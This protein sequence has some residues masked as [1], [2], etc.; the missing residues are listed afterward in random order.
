MLIGII[1]VAVLAGAGYLLAQGLLGNKDDTTTPVPVPTVIGFP[2]DR[3]IQ[4]LESVNLKAAV[5]TKVSAT[6]KPGRVVDQDPVAG[7][8]LAPGSTVTI[9]VAKAPPTV[10]VPTFTGLTLDAAQTLADTNHL[11]LRP[12]DGVSDTV[13]VGSI[14]S[15]DPPPGGEVPV[16]SEV[17]VVV[18]APPATVTVDDVTCL[19]FGAAKAALRDQGLVAVLGGTAP[20]LPQCPNPN[21]IAMQDPAAGATVD[22]GSTVTLFTGRP[23]RQRVRQGRRGRR[24]DLVRARNVHRGR[25]RILDR[26]FTNLDGPV[27]A[28][29]NLPEVVKGRCS[30]GTPGR[31][32]RCGDCSWTSSLRGG[33][34]RRADA[35]GEAR[36]EQLYERVFV[37]YGDDSVAQLGGVHL[38]C[39]QASQ[40]L[41]KALEWGRLAAYLEQ[42]TRYMRYDDKP[43]GAWRATVPPEIAR[44]AIE[45]RFRA[46]LDSAFTAYGRMYEPLESF[47][48]ERFPKE[49]GDTDFVY[50][51]TILAKTC[52]TL[53][54]LLPA[55]TRSNLGIYA[56]GQSYEQ[57]LMRL[58]AH[59]LAEM[60]EYGDLMLV[61][62][63]KVIP[64][65]LTRV[66]VDERGRA[67]TAYWRETRETVHDVTAKALTGIDPEPRPE[68]T[69]TDWDPDGEVKVI[70]AALYAH[71]DLPDDQLLALARELTPEQRAAVLG[72]TVGDRANRRH[73]PGR[74]WE[75]TDYRFDVCCD[76]GAFRDL[77]RHRPLTIEWQRLT[78]EHGF[79]TPAAIDE[80][81]LR[82]SG[83]GRW[84]RAPSWN[85]ISGTRGWERP[86]NTPWRWRTASG[87][88]CR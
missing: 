56:T 31:R 59:P 65:F 10:V 63:R 55:S 26:H 36:A 19:S 32:S 3:A 87:S 53:R 47:F 16:G 64:A 39:E 21:R 27:F 58:A 17:A 2:Q 11:V 54:L 42:S 71:S 28:L 78:T 33:R 50:R 77:Q 68:V 81:G 46:H 18:S 40:L 48:M 22:V 61:E 66:D 69:L 38:A 80:A 13:P 51:S 14:I 35:A 88:S 5:K 8:T 6:V 12:T 15:Q 70:A 45:Q 75:R 82:G 83:I 60:R 41:C 20:L 72:A 79:D 49:D 85:A 24:D 44:D 73:K 52:D 74:A 86:R 25:T 29:T 76:F 30:P 62:L 84:R 34:D 7:T 1:A 57:L 23:G 67:W 37:E 43:G 4:E 9:F